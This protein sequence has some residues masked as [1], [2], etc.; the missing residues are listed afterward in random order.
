M[1]TNK[2]VTVIICILITGIVFSEAK[3]ANYYFSTTIGDDN[4]TAA[5]AQNQSTPWRTIAKLNAI[6]T[7]LGAGDVI[8]FKRGDVFEGAITVSASGT[9]NNPIVFDA[10]DSGEKPVISGF[11]SVSNWVSAGN[12][13]WEASA[14]SFNETANIVLVNFLN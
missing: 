5:Q 9:A 1:K 6:F 8:Y 2:L 14:A 3:A 10:Y 11:A 12:N 13:I 7:T 4:R